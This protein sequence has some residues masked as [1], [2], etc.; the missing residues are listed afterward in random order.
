[1]EPMKVKCIRG[2][3][4]GNVVT[5]EIY[6]VKESAFDRPDFYCVLDE[7]VKT[8]SRE[9]YKDRFVPLE[10]S[11]DLFAQQ[12]GG[13]RNDDGKTRWDLL[14][15]DAMEYVARALTHG[16]TEYPERNWERG[17]SWTRVF[18]SLMRHSWAWFRGEDIDAKSGLPHM[19]LAAT[20]CLFLLT[21]H[22]R[23][24]GDDNRVKANV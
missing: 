5:G 24:V 15:P 1:M 2:N 4:I 11:K 10:V 23:N 12:V 9:W 8:G 16:L 18:G 20:N 7:T 13:F 14:P 19:A 22:L 3:D 17:M 6:T 21:Y